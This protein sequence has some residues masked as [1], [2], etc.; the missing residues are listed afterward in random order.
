MQDV[1]KVR[2]ATKSCGK[3]EAG[4]WGFAHV[5]SVKVS[6]NF[7]SHLELRHRCDYAALALVF[8]LVRSRHGHSAKLSTH[9]GKQ[10]IVAAFP[11]TVPEP[12]PLPPSAEKS[13][14]KTIAV[15]PNETTRRRT[16]P[17]PPGCQP[18]DMS[19]S[20][21]SPARTRTSEV[22]NSNRYRSTK[23]SRQGTSLQRGSSNSFRC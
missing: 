23:Q 18:T 6:R 9:H 19:M 2:S 20:P 14:A 16:P 1:V 4:A 3:Q 5:L 12:E 17:S 7:I 22:Q 21:K 13:F 15:G 11:P 8:G 10:K